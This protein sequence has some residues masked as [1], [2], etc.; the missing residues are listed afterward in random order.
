MLWKMPKE[1]IHPMI[2]KLV[3]WINPNSY[4]LLEWKVISVKDDIAQFEFQNRNV[5][6]PND[7]WVMEIPVKELK[8]CKYQ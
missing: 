7:N 5:L 2:Y 3:W 1:K 6:K 4:D 8:L